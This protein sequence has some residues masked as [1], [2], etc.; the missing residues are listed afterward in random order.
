MMWRDAHQPGRG[1]GVPRGV[2]RLVGDSPPMR[3]LKEKIP[4]VAAAPF[5]VVIEGESGTGKE[6]IARAIHEEGPRRAAAFV[7]VNCAVLGDELFESELFGHAKG[8]FT[9]AGQDRK[10]L[11]ELS[12]GGTVFLDEVAELTPRA[13][14]KLLRV[15]Q[16]GEVRR[17]GENRTQRLDLRVVAATNRPLDAEAAEGR[18]RKDLLYRLHVVGL[19]AP[20]LR[21]RGRDVARLAEHCWKGVAEAAGSRATLARE[22]VAALAAHPWPGNVWELQNVLANLT[23]TGPRYGP[24]GPGALPAAFRTAAPAERQPP[25]SEARG[26]RTRDGPRCPRPPPQ[27]RPRR[28]RAGRHPPGPLEADSPA[29]DRPLQPRPRPLGPIALAVTRGGSGRGPCVAESATP[30]PFLEGTICRERPQRRVRHRSTPRAPNRRFA[31]GRS[32]HYGRRNTGRPLPSI[33]AI[34]SASAG[35]S[36]RRAGRRDAIRGAT[37][38][39]LSESRAGAA[40]GGKGRTPAWSR[41]CAWRGGRRSGA[42][43]SPSLRRRFLTTLL[44]PSLPID[45]LAGCLLPENFRE[46]VSPYLSNGHRPFGSLN[47][48]FLKL[49]PSTCLASNR[50]RLDSSI[51]ARSVTRLCL[52]DGGTKSGSS[53]R[54]LEQA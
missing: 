31:G 49:L 11:L 27:R 48:I 14:A 37:G 7:P 19:T 39:P 40:N 9:G 54:L 32:R 52:L 30:A 6:L 8:A 26:S 33:R 25:L 46:S 15:L 13:Q 43:L 10:G 42:A 12:S 50:S 21:E 4:R 28:R 24:V 20:P 5:P 18:F 29:P 3:D 47:S 23:V 38:G 51:V 45:G 53:S 34:G 2:A 41:S 1:G 35:R 16:D 36:G 44:L 22:T 17:L